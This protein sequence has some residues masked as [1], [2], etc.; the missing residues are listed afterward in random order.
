MRMQI[1][2][3]IPRH[4]DQRRRQIDRFTMQVAREGVGLPFVAT[5][6]PARQRRQ[7]EKEKRGGK[8][9]DDDLTEKGEIIQSE[10]RGQPAP[11]EAEPC[12]PEEE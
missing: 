8:P 9:E 2:Q 10:Q 3:V 5:R 7:R 6:K 11:L 4:A 12:D 1:G